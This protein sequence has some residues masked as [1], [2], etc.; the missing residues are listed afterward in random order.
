MDSTLAIWIVAL[1]ILSFILISLL[2]KRVSEKVS[3]LI[4]TGAISLSAIFSFS[5]AYNYFFKT[6][7]NGEAYTAI[8]ANNNAKIQLFTEPPTGFSKVMAHL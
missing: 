1:P 6:F 8:I 7:S 4:A 2:G 5:I 3:A